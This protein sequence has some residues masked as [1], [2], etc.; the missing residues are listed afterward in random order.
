MPYN[1]N[2][3]P[4]GHIMFNRA[5]QVKMVKSSKNETPPVPSEDKF[6]ARTTIVA[7]AAKQVAQEIGSAVVAYVV[8]DTIRQV[9]VARAS[10]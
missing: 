10:K 5:L 9:L 6:V 3:L 8:L 4:K 7:Y 2:H 1:E